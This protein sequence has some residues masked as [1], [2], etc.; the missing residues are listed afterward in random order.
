MVVMEATCYDHSIF[1]IEIP[2]PRRIGYTGL[3]IFIPRLVHHILI[4]HI[5]LIILLRIFVVIIVSNYVIHM[6]VKIRCEP[7]LEAPM[8]HP[9]GI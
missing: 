6:S 2:S 1:I 8:P 3:V 7:S 4:F 9:T 5:I